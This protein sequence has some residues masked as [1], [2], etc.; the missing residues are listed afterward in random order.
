MNIVIA[1]GTGFVGSRLTEVLINQGHHVFIL[2]RSPEKFSNQANVTYVGWLNEGDQP[3][4]VLQDCEAMINLAGESLFGYWT[5]EKKKRIIDSRI[6]ATTNI[7]HLIKAMEKKPEVLVNASAV[8]YYGTSDQKFFTEKTI[9]SGDDFLAYVTNKWESTAQQAENYGVRVIYARFGMVLGEK[10]TLPLLSIPYKFFVGGPIGSGEQWLSWIHMDDAIRL[11]LFAIKEEKI[12]GP[13]N[14]TA[15]NPVR[16]KDLSAALAKTLHRPD[17]IKV[18][19]FVIQTMLGEMS[20]LVI[21]GQAVL[22]NKA[23]SNGYKYHYPNL[24][25]ALKSVLHNRL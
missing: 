9:S 7:V 18:P 1:G 14:I 4:K 12:N 24:Q 2:T 19:S 6:K 13:L 21:R 25:L 11:I 23:L 15:P 5:T 17:K 20:I 10:G 22:P 8:G 3:E 16:N